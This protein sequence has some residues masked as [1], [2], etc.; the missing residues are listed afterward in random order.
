MELLIKNQQNS[1]EVELNEEPPSLI[2]FDLAQNVNFNV[3]GEKSK[4]FI[5]KFFPDV[6]AKQWNNWHWQIRNSFTSFS[7]LSK[8]INLSKSEMEVVEKHTNLPVRITPYF[9]S[10]IDPNDPL[11]AIRRTMVPTIDETILSKGEQPDPLGEHEDTTVNCIVHRYPDRVLFLVTDFC[12]AYCRYCTRSHSVAKAKSHHAYK[13][14]WDKAFAYIAQN[15]QIRDVL[16]SGGDPLTLA[17][18][19]IEYILSSLKQIEHVEYIRIGTKVPVVLPQRI[20]PQLMNIIKKYHP[21]LMSVHFTHP[22]EITEETKFA[23]NRIANA[24]IPMGSQTVLLKGINDDPDIYKK[25]AHELLKIRVRPYY[26]YQCDP[27]PG[28]AHFRTSVEAGLNII[29]HLRGHTSGYANPQYVIDAPGGGGKIPLLPDYYVG[30]DEEGNVILKN[31][32][33][34]YFKYP[35]YV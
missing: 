34:K 10:L 11:Q 21:V 18:Y 16:I 15:K 25:L 3:L 2:N 14:E 32:E 30:K 24:G 23:C 12:S 13:S 28:S 26:L 20:T 5:A 29:R 31:Y 35:D 27:V 1:N 4:K 17:D 22:D 19:Q 9:A 8:V 6:T 7:D 33:N